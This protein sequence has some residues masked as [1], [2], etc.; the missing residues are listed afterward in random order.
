MNTKTAVDLLKTRFNAFVEKDAT[1]I[2][3]TWKKNTRPLNVDLDRTWTRLEIVDSREMLEYNEAWVEFRAYFREKTL[4]GVRIGFIHE[5]S[6]F[7]LIDGDWFYVNPMEHKTI[8]TK[9][10][11]RK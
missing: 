6:R 10:K 7:E 8:F 3:S 4:R 2:L 9:T 5:K 11:K 1:T